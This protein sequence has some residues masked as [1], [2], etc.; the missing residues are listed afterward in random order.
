MFNLQAAASHIK[1]LPVLG[2]VS[3]SAA[4]V[5]NE[6]TL[7]AFRKAQRLAF[8]GA[9]AIGAMLQEGWT[10]KKAADLLNTWLG[11]NGAQSFFHRAFVW[12]GDRTKFVGVKS[13]AGYSPT[14]RPL[15]DGDVYILDV[16]PIVDGFSCDIGHTG[17]MGANPDFDRA[18]VFL[19]QLRADIPEMFRAT[20]GEKVCA[21]IAD[22]IH[23][24]GYENIHETYPF[25]V[26]GHRL[27]AV[28]LTGPEISFLNFG[29]RSYWS[30]LSRGLFG[31]L[32]NGNFRGSTVGLWAIEPHIA[33]SQ[34]GAKFEEILVVTPESIYWLDD[35]NSDLESRT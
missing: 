3:P 34:F 35:T 18:M 5:P 28:P 22:R 16:A 31:Q 11:D 1:Q 19:R 9:R 25:S 33:T 7:A 4:A 14:S 29:W 20:S 32:L 23:A 6:E 2:R 21:L 8:A 24:A 30:L 17:V 27:H 10:E 12:W 15:R 13:Y 26:L